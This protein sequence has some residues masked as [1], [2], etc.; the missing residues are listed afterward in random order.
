[1]AVHD[2]FRE[3]TGPR[4]RI[5]LVIT[6]LYELMTPF[7]ALFDAEAGVDDTDVIFG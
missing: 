5:G 4:T 1:M 2:E 3:N 7:H 6:L